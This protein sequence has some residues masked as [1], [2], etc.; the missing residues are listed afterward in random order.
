MK[1]FLNKKTKNE[2][3]KLSLCTLAGFLLLF[4]TYF[5]TILDRDDISLITYNDNQNKIFTNV[6]NKELMHVLDKE[7]GIIILINSRK[8]ANRIIN[9]LVD[10]KTNE[11]IYIYNMKNDET[12]LK[13]NED[14]SVS[15][16][17][18]PSDFYNNLINK[19]GLYAEDYTIIKEDGKE[20]KTDYKK[21]YAPTVLFVKD[22][23]ILLSHYISDEEI[24]DKDLLEVYS[25]GHKILNNGY[26]S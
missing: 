11:K 19:L 17:Q 24:E 15:V 14:D 6:T 18:H 22:G 25:Q 3:I 16:K 23:K 26:N 5:D 20:I 2:L 1:K 21:I 8:T 9:L 13:L 7:T 10:V 4:L 12:I